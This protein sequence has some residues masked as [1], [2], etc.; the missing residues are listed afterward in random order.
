[1][2]KML[3]IQDRIQTFEQANFTISKHRRARRSR[4]QEGGIHDLQTKREILGSKDVE[5]QLAQETR[6]K[7]GRQKQTELNARR[8]GSWDKPGHNS[9]IY[10]EGEEISNVY[11]SGSLNQLYVLGLSVALAYHTRYPNIFPTDHL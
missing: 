3:L 8:C 1:M 11:N 10:Q 6:A 9:R 2:H 5:K 4:M 7:S